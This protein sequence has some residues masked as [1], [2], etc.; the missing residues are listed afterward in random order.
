MAQAPARESNTA[1]GDELGNE[2][3]FALSTEVIRG[4]P[5]GGSYEPLDPSE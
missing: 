3:P 5:Q 1:G 4:D 2:I